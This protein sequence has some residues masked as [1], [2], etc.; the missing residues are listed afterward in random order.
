MEGLSPQQLDDLARSIA[1]HS[2]EKHG[3]EFGGHITSVDDMAEAIKT[4]LTDPDTK[5]FIN[6]TDTPDTSGSICFFNEKTQTFAVFNPNQLRDPIA[7]GKPNDPDNLAGTFYRDPPLDANG[8]TISKN[9]GRTLNESQAEKRFNG[10]IKTL[11]NQ[12][13]REQGIDREQIPVK[14]ISENPEWANRIGLHEQGI[15][16]GILKFEQ[17]QIDGILG[18]D[19]L[20]S[21]QGTRDN[22]AYVLD[23]STNSIVT[24]NQANGERTLQT[25][26]SLDAAQTQFGIHIRETGLQNNRW[27][28]IVN[29][30]LDAL[31]DAIHA[32]GG[33]FAKA[34]DVAGDTL[35]FLGKAAKVL[36]PLGIFGAGVEA[37]QLE[38]KLQEAIDYGLV[39]EEAAL[40]YSAILTAHVGQGTLD[41]TLVGGEAAV[42]QAF[43]EWADKYNIPTYIKE[44]LEPGSLIE[45]VTGDIRMGH[46]AE[47]STI[48]EHLPR[49]LPDNAPPEAYALAEHLQLIDQL[50]ELRA[51]PPEGMKNT[52]SYSR[53]IDKQIAHAEDQLEDLYE[54][55][56]DHGGLEAVT[57]YIKDL[58]AENK[59]QSSW[60]AQQEAMYENDP[61][62]RTPG[63]APSMM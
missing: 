30:G 19:G 60:E 2:F 27:P 41:P 21:I 45:M 62:R 42:Q 7:P 47:L 24:I 16:D 58:L 32:R 53:N 61:L 31:N 26:D 56:R 40:E 13:A 29:G 43:E 28:Q 5:F 36:G 23:E 25:F 51:N 6:T 46:D 54:E 18:K 10:N 49:D 20:K 4:M 8:D 37:A 39:D 9:S 63:L 59:P 33:F 12:I 48:K 38:G 52:R 57:S 15:R 50:K 34:T 3:G 17:R 1:L 55:M 14:K 44:E 11:K 22:I 35:K